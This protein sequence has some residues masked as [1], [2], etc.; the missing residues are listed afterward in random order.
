M[1]ITLTPPEKSVKGLGN[2]LILAIPRSA[3][4]SPTGKAT[5]AEMNAAGAVD[6]TYSHVPDGFVY[7]PGYEMLPDD[8]LTFPQKREERGLATDTLV[9]TIV[10]GSAAAVADPLLIED[11]EF[12]IA[13]RDAV[14]H[15]QAIS[16]TDKWDFHNVEVKSKVKSPH[17][18]SVR[19]KV[20]TY[21]YQQPVLKDQVALTA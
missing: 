15:N 17:T 4:L 5:I 8:R 6:I 2:L 18:N 13:V 1:A 20:V 21:G 11:T 3:V 14:P 12:I 9:S 10:Y 7:T 16:A 19:T